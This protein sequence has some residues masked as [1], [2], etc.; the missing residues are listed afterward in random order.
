MA[1]TPAGGR[2]D[3]AACSDIGVPEGFHEPRL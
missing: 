3:L 2:V 1:A